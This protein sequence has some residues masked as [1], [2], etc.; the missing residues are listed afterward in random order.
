MEAFKRL[1]SARRDAV[2]N[3]HSQVLTEKDTDVVYYPNLKGLSFT[4]Q[5]LIEGEK[6][7]DLFNAIFQNETLELL[8]I[9]LNSSTC[10]RK[11]HKIVARSFVSATLRLLQISKS[12]LEEKEVS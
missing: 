12:L 3:I 1:P 11:W 5:F 2:I 8:N 10:F 6:L 7:E 9:A 4:G